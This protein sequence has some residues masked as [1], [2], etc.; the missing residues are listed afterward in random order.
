MKNIDK[1][2][3]MYNFVQEFYTNEWL[4]SLGILGLYQLESY[5]DFVNIMI[6]VLENANQ[7]QSAAIKKVCR[8]DLGSFP[9][10]VG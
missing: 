1:A 9:F 10:T 5:N 8:K 2:Q 4:L 3:F 6:E 7:W